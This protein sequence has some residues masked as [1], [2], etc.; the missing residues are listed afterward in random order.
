[1]SDK[2]DGAY[3]EL[4]LTLTIFQRAS[5]RMKEQKILDNCWGQVP[6]RQLTAIMGLSGSGKTSLLNV[7]AGRLQSNTRLRVEGD[8]RMDNRVINPS[9]IRTRRSMAFVAQDDSLPI[10][11]TPR[12]VI[13]FSAKMR[14]T[15]TMTEKQLDVLTEGM[16][17]ALGLS[18]CADTLVGGPLIK[19]ISGGERKRTSIGVEL[20]TKP[21]LIFLDEPTSGL[22]S[23]S[24]LQCCEVLRQVSLSG[25]GVL[26]TIHQPSSE[27][28]GMIDHLMLMR[29]GRVMYGGPVADIPDFFG[30]CG[31]PLPRNY[32][33]A[34]WVIVSWKSLV[35]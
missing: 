33:P 32:N 34:D 16:L 13:R 25:A 18:A 10:T 30:R 17:T 8:I 12:E 22:D 35:T 1:V 28:F 29:E 26:M 3:N 31:H 9:D 6:Q 20:V 27:V 21:A 7:L 15:R 24:A 11:S 2:D 5:Q 19:G 23:F 4:F 14:L